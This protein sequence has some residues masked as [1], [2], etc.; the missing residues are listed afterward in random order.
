MAATLSGLYYVKVSRIL[1]LARLDILNHDIELTPAN[2][3][4]GQNI[5]DYNLE[6]WVKS[7]KNK[8]ICIH[9]HDIGRQY[10]P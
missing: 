2:F 6:T 1:E 4:S 10:F 5:M 3:Q 7:N 8:S 9:I